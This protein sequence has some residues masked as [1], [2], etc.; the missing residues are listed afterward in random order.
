MTDSGLVWKGGDWEKPHCCYG[1]RLFC[2]S[3]Y[4]VW[5][6]STELLKCG[7]RMLGICG[8]KVCTTW[9]AETRGQHWVLPL[10]TPSSSF[11]QGHSLA[12]SSLARPDWLT[13]K[14][15]KVSCLCLPS[16]GVMSILWCPALYK[17]SWGPN[18][19]PHAY[20]ARA[21]PTKLLFQPPFT[22]FLKMCI[23]HRH[24]ISVW[25]LF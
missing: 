18:S 10:G 14:S 20:K 24:M 13:S 6:T 1:W 3:M 15:Q 22:G 21:L 2:F 25:R 16:T 8:V 4:M 17:G 23:L 12:W 9:H 11:E 5:N 7:W 19:R